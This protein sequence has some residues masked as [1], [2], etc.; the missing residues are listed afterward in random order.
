MN[1]GLVPKRYAKA[2]Y[3]FACESSEETRMYALMKRLA[4]SFDSTPA[5]Q[6]TLANPFVSADDKARL[7]ATAAG[8]DPAKDKVFA[9]VLAL[10]RRN[11][12]FALTHAIALAYIEAY[13]LQKK[14]R[15]VRVESASPLDETAEERLKNLI[16]AHLDGC[17]MEYTH[18]VNPELIGGFTV[19]TGNELLDASVANQL[20]QLRL[21]LISK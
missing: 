7:V 14:I 17:S 1:E 21:N 20:K 3:E 4:S 8:A 11:R 15:V 13:R 12:R 19:K 2:I 18:S 5:L 9:R 10:L 16:K 6:K